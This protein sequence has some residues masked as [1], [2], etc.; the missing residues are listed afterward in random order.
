MKATG[1]TLI[2]C[3]TTPVPEGAKGRIA[4]YSIRYNEAAL[5]A[6]KSVLGDDVIVDDLHAYC[7]PRLEKIQQQANVHFFPAGSEELADVVTKAIDG[8]LTKSR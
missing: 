6:V 8:V 7:Q 1:A 2:W 4:D 5:R 3:T